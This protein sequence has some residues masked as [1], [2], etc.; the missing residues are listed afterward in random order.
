MADG[1]PVEIA[2]VV[3]WSA[4][5]WGE[6]VVVGFGTPDS[7]A[8]RPRTVLRAVLTSGADAF[9]L[10][11]THLTQKP[12]GD[13][14]TAVTRH[15][16]PGAWSPPVRSSASPCS[17]TLSSVPR[18]RG[19]APPTDAGAVRDFCHRWS[20]ERR[21]DRRR[22]EPCDGALSWASRLDSHGAGSWRAV[23]I[24]TTAGASKRPH[25]RLPATMNLDLRDGYGAQRPVPSPG[26]C[27][28]DPLHR[29]A[30]RP[31]PRMHS[32]EAATALTD[33]L[34]RMS[35][36]AGIGVICKPSRML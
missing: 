8:A 20:G 11:H 10:V 14:D 31:S 23:R 28:T 18:W 22:V 34:G 29:S 24:L 36:R 15:P 32:G 35:G 12:P 13:D 5:D 16:S 19:S 6:P 1:L 9:L 27:R 26:R 4:G 3:P 7:V 17:D 2:F 21:G 25:P 33:G 30:S